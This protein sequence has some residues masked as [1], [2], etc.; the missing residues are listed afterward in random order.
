MNR[1]YF[2]DAEADLGFGTRDM[3]LNGLVNYL[4]V[5]VFGP[6]CLAH[7]AVLDLETVDLDLL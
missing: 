4:A 7:D 5:A 2:E 1:G 3:I 6:V